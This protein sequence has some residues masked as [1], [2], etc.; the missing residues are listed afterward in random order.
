[1]ASPRLLMVCR[2]GRS[3]SPLRTLRT[4]RRCVAAL[5]PRLNALSLNE[6]RALAGENG[7]PSGALECAMLAGQL[8]QLLQPLCVLGSK[9]EQH[10][11]VGVR[12]MIDRYSA[13]RR[14]A[15]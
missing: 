7:Q 6:V 12:K 13:E 11:S 8:I 10:G 1:M 2:A 14:A 3:R 4:L 5:R 9:V 15:R